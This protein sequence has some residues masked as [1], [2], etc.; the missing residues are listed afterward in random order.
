MEDRS[1]ENCPDGRANCPTVSYGQDDLKGR[2]LSF[3]RRYIN[4]AVVV[5]DNLTCYGET[6]SCPALFRF[7]RKKWG[8]DPVDKLR[9]N[10]RTCIADFYKYKSPLAPLFQRGEGGGPFFRGGRRIPFPKEG[11]GGLFLSQ[12]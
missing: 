10:P 5:F 6:K 8:K 12:G 3:F 9:W 1:G 11:Q 2:T 4:F 7:C